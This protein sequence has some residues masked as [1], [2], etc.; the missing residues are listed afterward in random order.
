MARLTA[1]APDWLVGSVVANPWTKLLAVMFA[2]GAWL[3]V[4][5]DEVHEQRITANVQWVLPVNLVTTEPL[6]TAVVLRVRGTREATRRAQE[7]VVQLPIDISDVG[8]GEHSLQ[9]DNFEAR[10]LPTNVALLAIEPHVLRYGLDEVGNRKV[11]VR[12][13]MVGDPTPGFEVGDVQLEPQVVDLRGARSKVASLREVATQPI[14]VSGLTQ[15]AVVGVNLDLPRGV[16]LASDSVPTATIQ[17]VPQIERRVVT[18]VPVHVWGR[19]DYR[20]LV[21]VVDVTLE[22]PTRQL[23]GVNRQRV[24]AFVQLP[25]SPEQS[26]YDAAFGPREGVRLRVVHPGGEDVAVAA[27][28]PSTIE[29]VRP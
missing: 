22:G 28:T 25:E 18:E 23:R 5:G 12:P 16:T 24:V 8:I 11:S 7:A 17:V 3:Y 26:R 19:H 4:Q 10:G 9:F 27:V 14:D 2:V 1:S 13:V 21:E 15:D 20:P 29:V 6:P